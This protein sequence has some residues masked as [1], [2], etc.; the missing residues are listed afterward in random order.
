DGTLVD[1]FPSI[2]HSTRRIF[3]EA[4][5][6]EPDET[7]ARRA[8]ADGRGLEYYLKI[9]HPGLD[10]L[11]VE[12][13][14]IR[15]REIYDAE[16][17]PFTRPYDGA[18]ETLGH[19]MEAGLSCAIISNKGTPA[20]VRSVN[21]HGFGPLAGLVL[22]DEP[23]QPKKP[24]PEMFTERIAPLYP[25]LDPMRVLMVGDSESDLRFGRAIGANICFASYGYGQEAACLAQEPDMIIDQV[26][27]LQQLISDNPVREH[28]GQ[29]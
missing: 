9:L 26:T 19:L 29:A 15:W 25:G 23:G 8:I 7:E 11:Q 20:L 24:K 21:E 10:D 18:L 22:G 14:K 16:A 17:H 3:A 4:G 1:S 28:H 6:S 13:W 2:L 27:E 5:L 12:E